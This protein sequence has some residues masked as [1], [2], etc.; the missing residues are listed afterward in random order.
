MIWW[1]CSSGS[2]V[3]AT[4]QTI[5][6]ATIP[7]SAPQ[8]QSISHTAAL[9]VL[10]PLRVYSFSCKQKHEWP[11]CTCASLP[12]A[13]GL[14]GPGEKIQLSLWVII[15]DVNKAFVRLVWTV[16]LSEDAAVRD[17]G[18][19]QSR[20]TVW[21]C[22]DSDGWLTFSPNGLLYSHCFTKRNWK[23]WVRAALWVIQ[24]R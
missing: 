1:S 24:R 16:V 19:Y 4:F 5:F 9:L 22:F 15:A 21:K 7:S 8:M 20:A 18:F 13:L 12:L 6:R 11:A 14:C 23:I 2:H 17:F 10:S 3:L